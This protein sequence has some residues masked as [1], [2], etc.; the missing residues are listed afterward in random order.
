[1]TH[2][3]HMVILPNKYSH[4]IFSPGEKEERFI[5]SHVTQGI[6]GN[7][8]NAVRTS[9]FRRYISDYITDKPSFRD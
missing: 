2:T 9:D 7:L 4:Y 5:Y 8:K 6:K 1:M 3:V